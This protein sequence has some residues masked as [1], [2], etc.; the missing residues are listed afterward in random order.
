MMLKAAVHKETGKTP[1]LDF[2]LALVEEHLELPSG[3]GLGLFALGRMA[4]WMAHIFEQ[5]KKAN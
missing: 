4:G 3:S 2:G 1:A 5:R